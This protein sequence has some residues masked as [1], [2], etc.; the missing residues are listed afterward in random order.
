MRRRTKTPINAELPE[1]GETPWTMPVPA[2]GRKYYR[3]GRN[4]SYELARTG[5]MPCVRTGP[6]GVL[7]LPKQIEKK[8]RGEA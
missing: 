2:A 1:D 8:L 4:R 7:A 3:A 5:V 6:R